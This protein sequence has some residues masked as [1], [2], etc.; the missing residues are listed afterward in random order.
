MLPCAS[1]LTVARAC[2]APAP[3]LRVIA[4]VAFAW[5][6]VA[7]LGFGR[8]CCFGQSLALGIAAAV[9][10]PALALGPAAAVHLRHHAGHVTLCFFWSPPLGHVLH[11]LAVHSGGNVWVAVAPASPWLWAS[12]LLSPARPWLWVPLLLCTCTIMSAA[13]Y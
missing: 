7:S 1:V 4:H 5:W 11:R 10:S 3:Q 12:L 9:A 6:Y 2:I 13:S 8:H